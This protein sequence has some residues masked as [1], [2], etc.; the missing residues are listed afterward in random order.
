MAHPRPFAGRAGAGP[1]F[2]RIFFTRL[3]GLGLAPREASERLGITEETARATLKRAFQKTGVT[4]QSEL[5]A[6]L[7]RVAVR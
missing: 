7:A 6:L 3:V 1:P 4:R 5:S 2:T